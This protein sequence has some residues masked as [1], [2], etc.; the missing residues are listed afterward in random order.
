MS[1]HFNVCPNF[2]NPV[3]HTQSNR[4]L[5]PL[6]CDFR[7]NCEQWIHLSISLCGL[8][9]QLVTIVRTTLFLL[10]DTKYEFRRV[11]SYC[12]FYPE[13]E[14]NLLVAVLSMS[15]WIDVHLMKKKKE[16]EFERPYEIDA[17]GPCTSSISGLTRLGVTC[18]S[19]IPSVPI[20]DNACSYAFYRPI[21][22]LDYRRFGF[23]ID[24]LHYLWSL[25]PFK[26]GL[27]LFY[28]KQGKGINFRFDGRVLMSHNIRTDRA[29]I[30][31]SFVSLR[32]N[33]FLFSRVNNPDNCVPTLCAMSV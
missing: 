8:N 26:S 30:S 12:S 33:K 29:D 5:K 31:L 4:L 28:R 3:L 11:L 24:P 15:I 22:P 14:S 23:R 32:L 1:S 2:L 9:R 27:L 6:A 21:V 7:Y 18:R 19:S 10:S 16:F 13:I 25:I 20:T 17:V